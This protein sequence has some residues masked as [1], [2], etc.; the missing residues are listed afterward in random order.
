MGNSATSKVEGKGAVSLKL[1]SGNIL[2]LKDMLYASDVRKNL[3]SG[4]DLVKKGFK[5]VFKNDNVI[6][7]KGGFFVG[8]GYADQGLFKLN[9]YVIDNGNASTSAYLIDSINIWHVRL[10]H[11]NNVSVK[12]VWSQSMLENL[13]L[14]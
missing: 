13:I 11:V 9:V 10:G 4:F 2:T 6:L 3:V 1:M 8:K 7:S 12:F 5:I 14:R